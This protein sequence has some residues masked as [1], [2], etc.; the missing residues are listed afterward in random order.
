M[1][2]SDRYLL[3]IEYFNNTKFMSA[4]T[5]LDEVWLKEEGKDKNFYG[6]LIQVAV[7]LYHLT[8][9]NPKGAQKIYEKAKDM[10]KVYGENYHDLRLAD[11]LSKLDHI[12]YSE[13]DQAKTSLDYLKILPRI[14]FTGNA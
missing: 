5:T 9:E 3:F 11:L 12:F 8:N 4:Q 2:Y 14:E 10:L 7:S 13:L 6:G 1:A